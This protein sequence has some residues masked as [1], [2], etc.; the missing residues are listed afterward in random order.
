MGLGGP[1]STWQEAFNFF[2]VKPM[3]ENHLQQNWLIL[4]LLAINSMAKNR[5]SAMRQIL[6]AAHG[7]GAPLQLYGKNRQHPW[8]KL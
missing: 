8:G 1:I 5:H 3:A 2:F 7:L 4:I 6:A